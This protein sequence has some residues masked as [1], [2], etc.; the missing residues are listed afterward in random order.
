MNHSKW[1]LEL[2]GTFHLITVYKYCAVFLQHLPTGTRTICVSWSPNLCPWNCSRTSLG[3]WICALP[4]L[5]TSHIATP[6]EAN[7]HPF[8]RCYH[9]WRPLPIPIWRFPK[10]AGTQIIHRWISMKKM[11]N[12]PTIEVSMLGN[13]HFST[14][15]QNRSV[16]GS[17]RSGLIAPLARLPLLPLRDL[18][19][20]LAWDLKGGTWRDQGD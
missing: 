20:A 9:P 16:L 19:F 2:Y 7:H 11:C 5:V 8:T 15:R 4:S 13:L 1:P 12:P 18:L 3:F 6:P 17:S 10:N 14:L